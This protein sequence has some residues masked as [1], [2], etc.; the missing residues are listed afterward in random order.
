LRCA[1]PYSEDADASAFRWQDCAVF[2]DSLGNDVRLVVDFVRIA[3]TDK[4]AIF[5]EDSQKRPDS[6]AMAG[7][8]HCCVLLEELERQ[9]EVD[10]DLVAVLLG[11]ACLET[12]LTA[13]WVWLGR[14]RA[15]DLLQ[16]SYRKHLRTMTENLDR[17]IADAK[18]RQQEAQARR[19]AVVRNNARIT[20]KNARDGTDIPLRPVPP[21]FEVMEV[22][23][24][25]SQLD[26]AVVGVPE[27][28]VTFEMM[29]QQIG[30]MS[31]AKG[32]GG[33]N[34]DTVY[35][36]LYRALSTW[37]AHPTYWL[38][39]SYFEQGGWMI[40]VRDRPPPDG[41]AQTVTR[42]MVELTA[43]LSAEVFAE[44]GIDVTSLRRL[45]FRM[46]AET[47]YRKAIGWK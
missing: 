42:A 30:P 3:I 14:D 40:H 5:A 10:G 46:R 16:G 28:D 15:L 2:T 13:T 1:T 43:M 38:L 6:Y 22:E 32:V 23:V 21:V 25:V 45:L 24:D 17:S 31:E 29:A 26:F 18:K 33:G 34:W 41:R 19:D 39:N 27:A 20:A 4:R 9:R 44:C 7:L 36:F 35:H 37:G 47:A 12:W 8:A 11:R